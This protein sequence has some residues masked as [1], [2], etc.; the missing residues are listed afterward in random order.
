MIGVPVIVYDVKKC[1]SCYSCVSA[2]ATTFITFRIQVP[3]AIAQ[4]E[5][6]K[7]NNKNDYDYYIW[8]RFTDSV[9]DNVEKK[10]IG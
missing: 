1:F 7:W 10:C 9:N 4:I 3:M 2:R 5:K 6:L 8:L